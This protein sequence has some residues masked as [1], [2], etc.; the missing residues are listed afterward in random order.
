MTA[1]I[2]RYDH[3]LTNP[4]QPLTQSQERRF[5]EA[6]QA[7]ERDLDKSRL[8]LKK[9]EGAQPNQFIP[10]FYRILGEAPGE[11]WQL[12]IDRQ[13]RMLR[14][15][16][17]DIQVENISPHLYRLRLKWKDPV[18]QRWD[19]ALIFRR[20][21]LRSD[22]MGDEWSEAEDQLL[23]SMYPTKDKLEL[24]K[25]FPL[26]SGMAIKKRASDLRV[27]RA[28]GR[29]ATCSIIHRSLC[30]ADWLKACEAMDIEPTSNEGRTVLGKLN[31][32]ARTTEKKGTAFWWLLPVMDMADFEASLSVRDPG[33]PFPSPHFSHFL[34]SLRSS[35]DCSWCA[36][37]HM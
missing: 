29:P 1:L 28:V 13:R 30:Y 12:D 34:E 4:A 8:A 11:F 9:Y 17:D 36:S 21:S 20:N 24:H 10:A 25:A 33:M 19:C 15:L 7:A 5:L 18:A 26:K 37:L 27:K 23:K 16:V 14:L 3:L 6:Q 35:L 2:A 31:Y 32:Y 22:L